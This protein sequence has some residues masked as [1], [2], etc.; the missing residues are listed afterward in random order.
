MKLEFFWTEVWKSLK[1]QILSK[2]VQWEPN[3][4]MRTDGR[5][6]MTKLLVALRNFSNAPKRST[7][8]KLDALKGFMKILPHFNIKITFV[9]V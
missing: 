5:T 3:G 1:Y 2:S 7:C 8:M 4:S 9:I 6:D